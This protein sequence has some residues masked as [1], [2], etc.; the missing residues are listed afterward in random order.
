MSTCAVYELLA[1]LWTDFSQINPQAKV[2]H[3]LLEERGEL[4]VNDHV[5]FRTFADSRVGM[6]VIAK[7]FVAAGY[8]QAETYRFEQKKLDAR[9]YEHEDP[10]LPKVFVSELR[11]HECSELLQQTVANLLNQI[12]ESVLKRPDF[13]IVG[14]PWDVSYELVNRLAN[15]SEYAGWMAAFGFR[16]NHFTVSVN[17]LKS[18]ATL[19]ELNELIK[20]AGFPLN[21]E[22]GEIKGSP[23]DLLEQSST[24]APPVS[25]LFE[26]KSHTVPGC[27]YEFARRYSLP[28]GKLFSGF[29]TQ[30]ADKIFQST[31]RR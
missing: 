1:R 5:A 30:N 27:Y 15:E 4:I 16:V 11:L 8:R 18:I 17:H 7:P 24:L 23:E 13:C 21:T 9:H 14:R 6:D 31:D 22:G 29:V 25:V 26:G 19:Q 28:N 12:P 2:I 10:H 3:S 20:Q